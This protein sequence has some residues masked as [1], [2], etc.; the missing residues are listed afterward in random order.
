[1]DLFFNFSIVTSVGKS[2]LYGF[3]DIVDKFF[4]IKTYNE[5][6]KVSY[7]IVVV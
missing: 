3:M 5:G 2:K 4:N 7:G 1:M 6:V